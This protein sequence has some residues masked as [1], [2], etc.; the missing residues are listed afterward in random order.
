MWGLDAGDQRGYWAVDRHSVVPDRHS[1]VLDRHM[2]SIVTG[3]R[4]SQCC[5][6]HVLDRHS[7]VPRARV[8]GIDFRVSG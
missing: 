5:T 7:V 4:S 1:V 8:L 3:T 2:Y 6:G